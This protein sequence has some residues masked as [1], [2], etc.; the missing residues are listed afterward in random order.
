[1]RFAQIISATMAPTKKHDGMKEFV[2]RLNEACDEANLPAYGRQS[3]IARAL[4][5]DPTAVKKWFHGIGHPSITHG[6]S[7]CD[8]LGIHLNWLYQ[9]KGPKRGNTNPDDLVAIAV[10]LHEQL[11]ALGRGHWPLDS[12]LKFVRSVLSLFDSPEQVTAAKV[13][14]L[15]EMRG[16]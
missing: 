13:A 2:A 1:M 4:Q 5:I 11:T 14:T 12:K 15:L 16:Q 7:L 10:A 6:N 8:F 3:Q 9:G